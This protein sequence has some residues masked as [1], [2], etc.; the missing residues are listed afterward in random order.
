MSEIAYEYFLDQNLF[1]PTIVE[2][3]DYC[4][5]INWL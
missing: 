2:S 1:D 4:S 3:K 5:Y